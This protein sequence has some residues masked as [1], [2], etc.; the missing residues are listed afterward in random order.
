M[1]AFRT[2]LRA[3]IAALRGRAFVRDQHGA[4]AIEFGILALP[5]FTLIF[6]ILET[7]M[8]FFAAQILDSAVQ[9]ASR[10]VRTGQAQL[11][12]YPASNFRTAIC[13]GLYGLFDCSKLKIKV[14]VISNF[15]SATA[16]PPTQTGTACSPTCNWT[17]TESYTPGTG[18]NV[19][20]VQAYYK[21]PVIVNLPGFNLQNQ[22]DGI[23][24]LGSVRVFQNEPF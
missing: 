10:L 17:I 4:V 16:T 8:I 14:S 11:A 3:G 21:W 13:N 9:D 2:R 1:A 12:N 15:A 19:I 18:S 20:M 7:T 5:F 24:L 22:P 6:A 23:R